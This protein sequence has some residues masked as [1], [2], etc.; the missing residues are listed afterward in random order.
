MN[1]NKQFMSM[2]EK[3]IDAVSKLNNTPMNTKNAYLYYN[4]YL[5]KKVYFGCGIA[6]ITRK[7]ENELLQI[8]ERPI[9]KKLGLSEKFPRELLYSRKLALGIGLLKPSTI[10][11]IL[12]TKLYIGHMRK[13]DRIANIIK[14]NKAQAEW[15]YGYS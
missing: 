4:M 1:W 3:L 2:K 11:A 13:N 9:I 8:C 14:I 7:Q 5:I 12:A 10:I 6:N 15:E